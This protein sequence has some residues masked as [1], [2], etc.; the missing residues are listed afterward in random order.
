MCMIVYKYYDTRILTEEAL[1]YAWVQ[2]NSFST[3]HFY[4]VQ[5]KLTY[6]LNV[7]YRKFAHW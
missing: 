2:G 1:I 7:Y 6:R 3:T 4:I 5:G